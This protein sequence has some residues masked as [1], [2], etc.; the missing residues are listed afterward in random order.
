[1]AAALIFFLVMPKNAFAYLNPGSGSYF[2]QFLIAGLFGL[3]F[4][5]KVYWLK[6]VTFLKNIFQKKE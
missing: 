6:V 4:V 1:M 3:I 5:L 2:F